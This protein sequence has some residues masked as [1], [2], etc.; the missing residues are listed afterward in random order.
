MGG[1]LGGSQLS[2]AAPP[3]IINPFHDVGNCGAGAPSLFA[4]APSAAAAAEWGSSPPDREVARKERVRQETRE[5]I[6]HLTKM[7]QKLC[8]YS[9]SF[10]RLASDALLVGW[11]ADFECAL[12]RLEEDVA[13][14]H[15]KEASLAALDTALDPIDPD[16]RALVADGTSPPPPLAMGS[17]AED[18]EDDAEE[19]AEEDAEDDAGLGRASLAR[20]ASA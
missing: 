7:K 9:A 20:W 2:P 1:G 4:A 14:L 16:T 11:D 3:R 19:D 12:L 15:R 18:A 10:S 5:Q 8:Q 13:C 17:D 6:P